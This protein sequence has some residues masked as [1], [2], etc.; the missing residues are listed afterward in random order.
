[1]TPDEFVQAVYRSAYLD[2]VKAVVSVLE[3]PPGQR[4]RA[5][6]MELS[7]WYKGL[8]EL[9]RDAAERL[10]RFSADNAVF[11]ILALIDGVRAVDDKQSR[12]QLTIEGTD[13]DGDLHEIFRAIVDEGGHL[14]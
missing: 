14:D 9:D 13:L 6:L 7:T 1:M 8:N 11:G 10:I 4:P 12:V 3:S 5:A 2:S